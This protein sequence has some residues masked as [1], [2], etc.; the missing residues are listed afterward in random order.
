LKNYGCAKF[1]ASAYKNFELP[2]PSEPDAR[3]LINPLNF[4]TSPIQTV[5]ST[6]F[7]CGKDYS[8]EGF[9]QTFYITHRIT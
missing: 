7:I 8:T 3:D 2:V 9:F 4:L 5:Y 1:F 6:M